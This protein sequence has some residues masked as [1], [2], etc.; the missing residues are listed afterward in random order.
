M[1][2]RPR[3]PTETHRIT[4]VEDIRVFLDPEL[5]AP[6]GSWRRVQLI[7]PS[8]PEIFIALDRKPTDL[9]LDRTYKLPPFSP[10][11]QIA[12][13]LQP[14]QFIAGATGSGFGV[15]GMIVEYFGG[16]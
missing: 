9:G 11:A 4:L 8:S 1:H 3:K 5:D 6:A 16:E 12:I 15:V 2:G 13:A 14:Q 10:G 7:I